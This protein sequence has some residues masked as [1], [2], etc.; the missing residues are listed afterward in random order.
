MWHGHCKLK[1]VIDSVEEIDESDGESVPR[2]EYLMN[3]PNNSSYD[4]DDVQLSKDE[5]LDHLR[6]AVQKASAQ[7]E[8]G[9]TVKGLNPNMEER[10]RVMTMETECSD[11]SSYLS[12]H[13]QQKNHLSRQEFEKYSVENRR[14]KYDMN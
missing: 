7:L 8:S 6:Y 14:D 10:Y 5:L 1:V 11:E 3:Y 13:S 4:K 9:K 2:Y 12:E